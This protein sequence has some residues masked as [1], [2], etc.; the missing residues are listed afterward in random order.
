VGGREQDFREGERAVGPP[1]VPHAWRNPSEDDE[2]HIVSELRPALHS[3]A[4]IEV[5]FGLARNL[6]TNR[7]NIPKRLLRQI[8]LADEAKH[9]F[10]LTG[11]PRPVRG[12]FS[13][14]L[15]RSLM[16]ASS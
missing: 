3:E 1:G 2:L 8:V 5:S 14:L 16:S 7:K 10:Y 6:K 12:V 15:G 11:V 9:E 4:L 13:A